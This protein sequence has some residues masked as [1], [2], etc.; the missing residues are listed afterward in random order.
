MN[1]SEKP[2]QIKG[3]SDARTRPK[4]ALLEEHLDFE[5]TTRQGIYV[6]RNK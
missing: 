6:H 4:N 2:W 5:H 1:L 3:E